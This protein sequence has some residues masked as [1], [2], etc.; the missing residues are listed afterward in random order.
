MSY[1][2]SQFSAHQVLFEAF[3][4]VSEYFDFIDNFGLT[5][6]DWQS[7]TLTMKTYLET[8]YRFKRNNEVTFLPVLGME[9]MLVA[10]DAVPE[11]HFREGGWE[12]EWWPGREGGREHGWRRPG[13]EGGGWESGWRRPRPL[14]RA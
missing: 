8:E 7:K 11:P 6:S 2:K 5:F 1:L 10:S 3:L 13:R 12:S 4:F 9:T 14:P